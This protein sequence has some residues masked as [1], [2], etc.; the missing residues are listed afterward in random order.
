MFR[1][2]P[3][4][5]LI[6]LAAV[7]T[8]CKP[9]TDSDVEEIQNQLDA[10]IAQQDQVDERLATFDELDFQVFTHQEWDR[11][12]ESHSED[13]LVHWPDGHTT[14]GI[15]VHIEDLKGMFVWAPDTRIEQHPIRI[16]SGEFTAVT[17]VLQGTFTEPM[18]TG[19][20]GFIEPTGKAYTISMATIGRWNDAGVME[21]EWL[22]WD[23]LSFYQQIGLAE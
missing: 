16:G 1:K 11:L 18:P 4:L 19:D 7:T 17:G 21:E 2:L 12:H 13:I 3:V 8:A 15:D 20:G 9:S 22:F 10:L 5:S 14:T 23:N 6:I